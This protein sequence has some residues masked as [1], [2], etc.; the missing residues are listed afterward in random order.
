KRKLELLRVKRFM[1]LIIV[2][3]LA[4]T[5]LAESLRLLYLTTGINSYNLLFNFDY[6]PFIGAYSNT[7]GWTGMA[8]HY[9]VCIVSVIVSYYLFKKYRIEKDMMP[10]VSLFFFGSVIVYFLTFFSTEHPASN[11]WYAFGSFGLAHRVYG[12]IVAKL[13][14]EWVVEYLFSDI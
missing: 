11:D 5:V 4:G 14:Q 1:K 8:F 13:I 10:Y 9:A 2:G 7:A 12:I 6:V 3:V